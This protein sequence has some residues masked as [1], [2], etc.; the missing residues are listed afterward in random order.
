MYRSYVSSV[1]FLEMYKD[2]S[3][4]SATLDKYLK[5]SSRD[6]DV[7]TFNRILDK[8]F[9]NLTEYQQELVKEVCFEHTS[10]LIENN[11]LLKTYLSS[12]SINDVSMNFSGL[13]NVYTQQGVTM[14]KAL[15][16]RL[17]STGLCCRSIIYG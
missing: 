5:Q 17:C 14:D 8:G 1:E 7:L 3:L 6:I 12:Y 16:Q 15:Y 13:N 9:D 4:D 10:F 11:E 2:T